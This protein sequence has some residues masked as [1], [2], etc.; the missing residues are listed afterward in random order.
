VITSLAKM[1]ISSGVPP[2]L[3]ASLRKNPS[4]HYRVAKIP[5]SGGGKR[6]LHAPTPQLKRVQ[7]V[8]LRQVLEGLPKHD[9]DHCR[10]GRSIK[11]NALVHVGHRFVSSYDIR[12]CFPSVTPRLVR[13][14]LRKYQ[15]S[16]RT[17]DDIIVLTMLNGGLPQG[18]P[19]SPALLS[20]AVAGMD[21]RLARA[22]AA[23]GISYTRYVDDIF[24]SGNRSVKFF[25]REVGAAVG[26]VGLRINLSKSKHWTS[27]RRATVTGIVLSAKPSIRSEYIA[28]IRRILH[29]ARTGALGLSTVE[30]EQ[31]QGRI[32]WVRSISPE[33]G[34]RL[35]AGLLRT[36]MATNPAARD[37]ERS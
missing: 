18:A 2:A 22:A 5:K 13:A 29:L 7:R 20:I 17:I 9:A 33:K 23:H 30:W 16:A 3:I 4:A 28:S 32:A 36:R 35:D 34:E 24:V 14:A 27:A 15:L 26:L 6:D 25:G 21:D 31:L 1:L 8:V 19:T 12:D 10:R 37:L 11:T